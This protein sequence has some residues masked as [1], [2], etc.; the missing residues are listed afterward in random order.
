MRLFRFI[1]IVF[2]CTS[3]R[4][5]DAQQ[6]HENQRLEILTSMLKAAQIWRAT[7]RVEILTS[8]ADKINMAVN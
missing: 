4:Q 2:G 3:E 6:L 8:F 7:K 1:K 5:D